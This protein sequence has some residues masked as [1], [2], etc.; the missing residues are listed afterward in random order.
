MFRRLENVPKISNKDDC[1]L[2]G[3]R[4]LPLAAMADGNLLGLTY[5]NT[6]RGINAV[7]QKLPLLLQDWL[8]L[9]SKYIEEHNVSHVQC[10]SHL[11]VQKDAIGQNKKTNKQNHRRITAVHKRDTITHPRW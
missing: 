5:I 6:L 11:A 7:M 3:L 8:T 2:R 9:V 1:R 4:D 10:F